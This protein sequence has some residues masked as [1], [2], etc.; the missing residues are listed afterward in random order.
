MGKVKRADFVNS[1]RR[2]GRAD[3]IK[4]RRVFTCL[5]TVHCCRSGRRG[6]SSPF[7]FDILISPHRDMIAASKR[8]KE[9]AGPE[10]DDSSDEIEN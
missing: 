6:F 7:C 10:E 5:P 4:K 1:A 8:R 3:A 9:K 2:I